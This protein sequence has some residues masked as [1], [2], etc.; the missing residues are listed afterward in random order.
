MSVSG[1]GRFQSD[2]ADRRAIREELRRNLLVEAAAGT[3]KTT[4][5]VDR[6]LALVAE[7]E[8]TVDRL[9]AVTFTVKAAAQLKERFQVGLEGSLAAE[10]DPVKR[11]RLAAALDEIDRCFIGTIHSF[12]AR[13]LRERPVEAGVDPEFVELDE[14]EDL[15]LRQEAWE[16]YKQ[17]L[18]LESSPLLSELARYGMPIDLLEEAYQC[19]ASNPD[20][21]PAVAG[22]LPE[23][24][25]EHEREHVLAFLERAAKELP[26][27]DPEGRSD[28]LQ[29]KLRS[30]LR[31]KEIRD[32]RQSAEL[33]TL[34]ERL[35]GKGRIVQ[36]DWPNAAVAVRLRDAYDALVADVVS[37]ALGRWREF[38]YPIAVEAVKPAVDV[39]RRLRRERG[40]LDFGDLLLLARNLLRDHPEARHDFRRR[41]TPV[42]VDEFQ[43]TDPIQA[44]VLLYLTGEDLG[45]KDWR[46]LVPAPGS[47][48][49]VGDPKQS[50]YRFRRADIETYECVKERILASGGRVLKLTTNFRSSPEI[51]DWI[52]DF[53]S[54]TF[55]ADASRQ[56]A[57]DAPLVPNRG[58]AGGFSGVVRLEIPPTGGKSR[59]DVARADAVRI[60]SWIRSA[61]DAKMEIAR[62]GSRAALPG[63][64][65]IL[66]RYKKLM[67]TY[68]RELEL[69]GIPYE[70]AGG[71]AFSES[72]DLRDLLPILESIADPDDPVSLVAS[73]RGPVFGVDDDA[74]YRHW[75]EGGRFHMFAPPP[76]A[77]DP[78]ILGVMETLR[79]AYEV[80]KRYPPAAAL[81]RIAGRLGVIA[82]GGARELGGTR[83]GNLLKAISIS[84]AL[85]A[86]GE[87]FAAIVR[88]LRRLTE[89]SDTE[90]MSTSPGAVRAVRLLTL[91]RAKGLEAPVVFLADPGGEWDAPIDWC[92]G[93]E[94]EPP[95]AWLRVRRAEHRDEVARPVGWSAREEAEK[96]F[97]EAEKARLLYVAATRAAD[98]LVVSAGPNE[99]KSPWARLAAAATRLLPDLPSRPVAAS[100]LTAPDLTAE[101]G[102][103]RRKVETRRESAARSTYRVEPVTKLVHEREGIAPFRAR[104]GRGMSWGRVIHRLL[105]LAMKDP[106]IDLRLYA[107]NLLADEERSA[108]EVDEAVRLVES[109]R[110]SRLWR[111]ALAAGRRLTEVPFALTAKSADL[112]LAPGGPAET[113]LQGAI[114]L[115]FEEDSGWFIVDYKSDTIADN[116]DELV[117]YYS[118]QIDLY[119]SYWEKLTGRPTKAGLYFVSTQQE[120]WPAD[121]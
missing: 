87:S 81:A 59:E 112:G 101:L 53:F 11:D 33:V 100:L 28:S 105:E 57:A 97:D 54:K 27:R 77:P 26:P 89:Q 80:S 99:K 78:R 40:V 107:G 3:G 7:G 120:V 42:L 52:N 72:E 79:E 75:R 37:P 38:L 6:M 88:H 64:F 56:Q 2:A 34:F 117:A 102:A 91:H 86:N 116:L 115:A 98:L 61:L 25:F 71:G 109:V 121:A 83:A 111:R 35:Q 49:V 119:R 69:R 1:R 63:D 36:R 74:L 65:L 24:G 82:Y 41:F 104:T 92:V 23:P 110:G 95:Q 55:P 21:E 90:E 84:R 66:F 58:N 114:D 30:A 113:V 93:R 5:L 9:C 32:L 13:L 118:P 20:V 4:S 19:L 103:F 18:F 15:L 8:A 10:R 94:T 22:R 43:D 44:E 62:D 67:D 76:A 29:K 39:F 85:S 50:I 68:A 12:C 70:I 51:C 31:L 17:S 16:R 46:R 73:L 96:Q 48:F 47:L 106:R 108:S 45:E 14:T 60:A